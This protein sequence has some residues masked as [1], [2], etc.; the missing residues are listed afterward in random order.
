MSVAEA[1]A[2]LKAILEKRALHCSYSQGR[3]NSRQAQGRAMSVIAR[4]QFF[5]SAN[6]GFISNRITGTREYLPGSINYGG[7]ISEQE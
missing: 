5:Q 3:G 2:E 7:M 1:L 4:C 6:G